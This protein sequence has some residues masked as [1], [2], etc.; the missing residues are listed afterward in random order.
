MSKGA[1]K[2][3]AIK[4]DYVAIN[5]GAEDGVKVGDMFKVFLTAKGVGIFEKIYSKM[6][7]IEVAGPHLAVGKVMES[8]LTVEEGY[9]VEKISEE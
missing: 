8:D 3:G 4:G 5:L 1:E 9:K 6:E 2:N 7:I